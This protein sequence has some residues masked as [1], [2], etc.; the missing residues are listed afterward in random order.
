MTSSTSRYTVKKM[1]DLS[2]ISVRTLHHYD[3]IGLLKPAAIGDNTYRYYG[4]EE[5]LRLQ[6]ILFHR[7]LGFSLTAIGV[8]LDDPNFD[9]VSA[10]Q[11]H[12]AALAA[13]AEKTQALIK[14]I[15]RTLASLASLEGQK[16]MKD[17]DLYQGFSLEQQSDYEQWLIAHYGADMEQRIADSTKAYNAMSTEEQDKTM[18]ELA[19][20]EQGL[21][22]GLRQKEPADSAA[23]D[24]LLDRHRAWV[25]FMWDR[26][27]PPEAYAGLAGLY[28]SHPDFEKRY[29]QIEPGFTLY[30]T[31]AMKAYATRQT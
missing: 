8:A 1:A 15:D 25:A 11:S 29:E 30:L 5:L 23:H 28:L 6:Q 10:L 31:D 18:A 9:D 20:I 2:G 26:P 24:L 19:A 16:Q 14:T 22:E 13:E 3:S 12:R 4:R 27:C 17:A 7:A 21:A